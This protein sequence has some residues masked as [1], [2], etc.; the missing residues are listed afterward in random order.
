[1][2]MHSLWFPR[3]E[4]NHNDSVWLAQSKNMRYITDFF[5]NTK[6]LRNLV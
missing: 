2:D 1:M 4:I 6:T 5:I 3:T